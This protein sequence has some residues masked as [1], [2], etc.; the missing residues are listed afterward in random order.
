MAEARRTYSIRTT[1]IALGIIEE[2]K[3]THAKWD[4]WLIESGLAEDEGPG[5]SLKARANDLARRCESNPKLTAMTDRGED[6]A[7]RAIVEEALAGER[8][9]GRNAGRLSRLE[10]ALG[11]DGYCLVPNVAKLVQ[12]DSANLWLRS[13]RGESRVQVVRKTTS[14]EDST[15]AGALGDLQQRLA[16]AGW[17]ETRKSLEDALENHTRGNWRSGNADVRVFLEG[18][19]RDLAG[20]TVGGGPPEWSA[21]RAAE[22]QRKCWEIIKEAKLLNEDEVEYGRA[23]W[24]LLHLEGPHYGLSTGTTASF[25][26]EAVLVFARLL[27]GRDANPDEEEG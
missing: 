25:R 6:D 19:L 13:T 3:K 7:R 8:W 4:E 23:L 1:R 12:G 17:T 9:G 18:L 15:E 22:V 14:K 26:I 11:L 21:L 5:S 27:L 20:K 24:K 16:D 10:R 2:Q